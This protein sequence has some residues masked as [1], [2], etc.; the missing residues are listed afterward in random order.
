MP[1]KWH[2]RVNTADWDAVTADMNEVGGALLPQLITATE[3]A[4]MLDLY[5][6][7]SLFR[8]II[9]MTRHRYGQIGRAHV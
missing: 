9:D 5:P 6:D 2:R 8:A 4:A 1:S 7:D 3:C